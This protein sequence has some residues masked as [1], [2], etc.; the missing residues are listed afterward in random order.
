MGTK[1]ILQYVFMWKVLYEDF[2]GSR[3][4][5]KPEKWLKGMSLKSESVGADDV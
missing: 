3:R 1:T 5:L 2:C 4:S